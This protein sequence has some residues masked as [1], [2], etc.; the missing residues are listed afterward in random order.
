MPVQVKNCQIY[1]ETLVII[2]IIFNEALLKNNINKYFCIT[3]NNP[4]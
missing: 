2:K 3:F 1:Q 4:L